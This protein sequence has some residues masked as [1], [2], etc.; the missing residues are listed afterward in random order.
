MATH[1]AKYLEFLVSLP[2]PY[3]HHGSLGRGEIEIERDPKKIREIERLE[4]ARLRKKGKNP[5]WGR[6]GIVFEN[7]WKILVNDPVWIPGRGGAPATPGVWQRFFWK[8]SFTGQA[9]VIVTVTEDG[10][11]VLLPEYRPVAGRWELSWPRGGVR[12]GDPRDAV[13][14]ELE[15]EL[16]AKAL[17][18]TLLQEEWFIAESSTAA[19]AMHF[20]GA[21]VRMGRG[22]R[23]ERGEILGTPWAMSNRQFKRALEKG[24]VTDMG[25]DIRL[26]LANGYNAHG[27]F[28]AKACGLIRT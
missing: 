12:T 15:Q 9:V 21:V 3:R 13:R 26:S 7:E 6:V 28:L 5:E 23:P 14:T 27:Y 1:I 24:F 2:E 25:R 10:D 17:E 18:I 4:M 20:Y 22:Q 16:G 11:L 19:T 8:T